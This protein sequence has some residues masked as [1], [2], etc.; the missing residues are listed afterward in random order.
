M[1]KEPGQLAYE[2]WVNGYRHAPFCILSVNEKARWARVESA[3]RADE[4][5][6]VRAATIEECAELVYESQRRSK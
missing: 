6:K 2:E 4:R 1:S 5:A 3:I